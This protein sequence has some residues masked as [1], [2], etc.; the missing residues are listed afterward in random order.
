[1]RA[2]QRARFSFLPVRVFVQTHVE[3]VDARRER[4]A[5]FRDGRRERLRRR[6]PRRL[7]HRVV[8][9]HFER[10]TNRRAQ[11]PQ[12]GPRAVEDVLRRHALAKFRNRAV[13]QHHGNRDDLA[14][15]RAV[16]QRRAV[17]RRRRRAADGLVYKPRE[18]GQSVPRM[19]VFVS[20]VVEASRRRPPQSAK[21]VQSRF[22]GRRRVLC[23]GDIADV[24]DIVALA[25][26][27]VAQKIQQLA[28]GGARVRRHLHRGG[29]RDEPRVASIAR[30]A[31][32][33]VAAQKRPRVIEPRSRVR[34]V[35]TP[36]LARDRPP[37]RAHLRYNDIRGV[38]R[39][40]GAEELC[41]PAVPHPHGPHF[42]ERRHHPRNVRHRLGRGHA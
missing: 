24:A 17:R 40:P 22:R 15:Q 14:R 41:V 34:R 5:R 38:A 4:V 20:V 35:I 26:R 37:H 30:T 33:P 25:G 29:V 21:H 13:R 8:F 1:M 3:R 6:P 32:E 11:A 12:A 7:T 2:G 27:E 16:P 36:R 9:F 42:R 23:V 19:R 28:H 18:R 31:D 10:H 39:V